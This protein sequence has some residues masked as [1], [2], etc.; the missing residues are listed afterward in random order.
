MPLD[1]PTHVLVG[2]LAARSVWPRRGDHGLVNLATVCS[3]L[4]DLDVFWPGD[5]VDRLQS[6]R[7]LS[8]SLFGALLGAAA[9]AWIARRLG[10]IRAPFRL[11][12]AVTL[13]AL[14]VHITFDLLTSYGTMVLEPFSDLRVSWDALFIIDPYLAVIVGGGLI[15]GRRLGRASGY[16]LGS[17]AAAAYV[18]LSLGVTGATLHRLDV[19]AAAEGIAVD[20]M[21]SIPVPFSPLHRRG[22]VESGARVYDVPVSLFAG[23]AGQVNAYRAAASDKRL[24]HVWEG[25]L[26]RVYRWFAR[27]PVVEEERLAEGEELLVQDLRFHI[28]PDG[29]GWLG[30]AAAKALLERNPETLQRG[31][32]AL[33]VKLG[34]EGRADQVEFRGRRWGREMESAD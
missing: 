11:T 21:S 29:L 10:L 1:I 5:A 16:R 31:P 33:R 23:V 17:A 8:H 28:R 24:Q 2:R 26:G 6:H 13:A 27:Y 9:V 25:R 14:L 34:P 19:W 22:A 7:G 18:L 32:F 4:P 15:L 12:Y 3:I 20:R 30:S